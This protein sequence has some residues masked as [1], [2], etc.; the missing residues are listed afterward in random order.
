MGKGVIIPDLGRQSYRFCLLGLL[1][2][3]VL[4][5][6]YTAIDS[7]KFGRAG[8]Q[9]L[10]ISFGLWRLDAPPLGQSMLDLF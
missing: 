7:L 9:R 1:R 4:S 6:V 8:Y 2:Y 3:L 5:G 10:V